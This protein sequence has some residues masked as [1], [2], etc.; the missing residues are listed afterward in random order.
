MKGFN[1]VGIL[2]EK[3]TPRL[4]CGADKITSKITSKHTQTIIA[5]PAHPYP[6]QDNIHPK[7]IGWP[8]DHPK[9][10]P[11]LLSTHRYDKGL[12]PES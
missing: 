8:K 12:L 3:A 4:R 7:S 9:A 5:F 6:N 10:L 1:G 2:D 11:D